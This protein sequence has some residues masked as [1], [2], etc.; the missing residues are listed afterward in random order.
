[1]EEQRTN[2]F[3]NS[4]DFSNAVWT[5]GATNCT[6]TT[7]QVVSPDGTLSGD[8]LTAT[9]SGFSRVYQ[10]QSAANSTTYTFS[11]WLKAGNVSNVSIRIRDT[12]STAQTVLNVTLTSSWQ[13]FNVSQASS[14]SATTIEGHVFVNQNGVSGSAAANDYI[15]VWGGQMEAGAFPTSYIATTSASV[16]RNADAASMTGTNFSSW[17]RADEGSVYCDYQLYTANASNRAAYD[18]NDNSTN[19][20]VIYRA[21]TTGVTD[22]VII[23]NAGTTYAQL[24]SVGSYTTS[25]TK[26][27]TGYKVNDFALVRNAAT[28]VTDTSGLVPAGCTQ[29][30]IGSAQGS[31][32]YLSGHIRKLAYYPSRLADA[33]LQALTAS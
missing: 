3:T 22:Q 8:Q 2:L 4:A 14:A 6:V 30:L 1:V 33:Q 7:N 25:A 18:I 16:T 19:N 11:V 32:E 23:R 21:A 27:S 5:S 24:A 20:R 28:P 17:F 13:R 15:Y 9:S 10:Q 26:N 31:V 29:I 12:A